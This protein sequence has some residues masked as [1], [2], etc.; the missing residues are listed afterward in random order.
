MPEEKIAYH[1]RQIMIELE[2]LGWTWT[3]E[4]LSNTPHRIARWWVSWA[5]APEPNLTLFDCN[6]D[7]LV[8]VK[9]VQFSSLCSHHLVPYQG[10]ASLAYLPN[11]TVI[12]LSK[13]PRLI[14]YLAQRPTIQ[15]QLTRQI[16]DRFV[17]KVQPDFAI[18]ILKAQH[19]CVSCRGA[20]DRN[21]AM[22]TSALYFNK[23][24]FPTYHDVNIVKQEALAL[25]R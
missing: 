7:E 8:I 23:K 4:E 21:A 24:R 19:G 25:M 16:L 10:V 18:L 13:I 5:S 22:T 20:E 15:E 11:G 14:K 1:L 2:R 3:E 17:E 9:D 6:H 12:G